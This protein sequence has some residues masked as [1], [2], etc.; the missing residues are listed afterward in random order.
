MSEKKIILA[1][2]GPIASGKGVV[3]KYLTEKCQAAAYRFS[4]VLRQIL[5]RVYSP[6][7]RENMQLLSTILRKNFGEDIL[8]KVI[9]GDIA[10]DDS[11]II[12]IDGVRRLADIKYL[13]KMDGF[14]LVRVVADAQIRY[15]RL[16]ARKENQ[17]D[18]SKTYEQFLTD[19]QGEADAQVPEVMA[20]ASLEI[21]NNG[22]LENLYQQIESVIKDEQN[23]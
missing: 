14:K 21:N 19:E 6:I 1:L 22:G 17:D 3:V 8:A 20:K 18:E 2:V 11:S 7:T 13:E 4:T 23:N 5:E 9:A 15:Q 12:V 10:K 16:L